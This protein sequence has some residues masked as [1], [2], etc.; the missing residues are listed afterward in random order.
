MAE[1]WLDNKGMKIVEDRLVPKIKQLN[2]SIMRLQTLLSIIA[3][4][5]QR[6]TAQLVYKF[7]KSYSHC[8][9]L[10]GN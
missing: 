1:K 6:N 3:I 2:T 7:S 9:Q 5:W 8:C 4:N 10:G